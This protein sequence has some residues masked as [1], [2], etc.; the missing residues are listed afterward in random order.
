MAASVE[1]KIRALEQSSRIKD[2]FIANF[3]HELKTPMTSIIGYSDKLRSRQLDPATVFKAANYIYH[4]AHRL[5]ALSLKMLNLV[6]LEQQNF[7]FVPL[8]AAELLRYIV[9][10]VMPSFQQDNILIKA[11]ARE[12]WIQAEPDLMK[13]LLLNIVDNARKASR[14]GG[15][16]ELRGSQSGEQYTFTVTDHGWG[17]PQEELGKI[18]EAFYMGDKSRSRAQNGAG[19]GLSIASRIAAFHKTTLQFR[20]SVGVGTSV[21]FMLPSFHVQE[22][23]NE[24]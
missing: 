21:S 9:R 11:S 2:D 6:V 22:H 8:N 10:A 19:L 20:S 18:T 15:T 3:T 13:T 17:I 5:E 1:E 4:E 16:V 14:A 12:G 7:T 24:E 23:E